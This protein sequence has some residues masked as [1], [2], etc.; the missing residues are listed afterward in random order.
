VDFPL[1]G[2]LVFGG[3][4]SIDGGTDFQFPLGLSLGRRVDVEDSEVS[5]VPYVQPTLFLVNQ[6]LGIVRDTDVIFAIGVG[7]DFRLSRRF[8]ARVSL[9]FGDLDGISIAAVWIR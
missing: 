3:G 2:A 5:I 9:G 7:G 8:D 1:D 4:L 6:D